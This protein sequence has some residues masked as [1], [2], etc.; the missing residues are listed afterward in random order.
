MDFSALR[1]YAAVE[2]VVRPELIAGRIRLTIEKVEIL[3][4]HKERVVTDRISRPANIAELGEC[5]V[6][7]NC[8][9]VNDV[10]TDVRFHQ[11]IRKFDVVP[12]RNGRPF[13]QRIRSE[14]SRTAL[15]I[16]T[17]RRRS[18]RNE[19][20]IQPGTKLSFQSAPIVE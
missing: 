16:C 9:A 1:I 3:L 19:R 8:N 20:D 14:H 11:Q 12:M 4:P 10:S 7:G 15:G 6:A 2:D 17:N 5:E 13:R 18:V